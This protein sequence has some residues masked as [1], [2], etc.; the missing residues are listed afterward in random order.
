MTIAIIILSIY[1]TGLIIKLF[2][3]HKTS[4]IIRKSLIKVKS[5]GN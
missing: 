4:E 2:K 5:L 3:S 1:I